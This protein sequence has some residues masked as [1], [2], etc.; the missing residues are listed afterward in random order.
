M[1]MLILISVLAVAVCIA[2][3]FDGWTSVAVQS[4]PGGFEAWPPMALLVRFLG[5]VNAMIVKGVIAAGLTAYLCWL[6]F[7]A[8]PSDRI[9]VVAALAAL[10][11]LEAW[12]VAHNRGQITKGGAR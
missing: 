12:A 3:A 8:Q 4:R 2:E 9:A 11:G 6:G 1:I 10:L 7:H 5:P